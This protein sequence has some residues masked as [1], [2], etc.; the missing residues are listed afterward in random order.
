MGINY[1]P[2]PIVYQIEDRAFYVSPYY[3]E[4]ECGIINLAA[5]TEFYVNHMPFTSYYWPCAVIGRNTYHLTSSMASKEEAMKFIKDLIDK[6][7][8]RNKPPNP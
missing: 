1:I 6:I 4:C 7:E 2:P 8:R 5:A 3:Y